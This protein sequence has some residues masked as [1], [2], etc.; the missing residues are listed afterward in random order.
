M[1]ESREI[2]AQVKDQARVREF[3]KELV[4]HQ[5]RILAFILT[6]VPDR[7]DAEDILQETLYEMWN[8]FDTFTPGTNFVA[9]GVTIAKYKVLRFREKH[10]RS[11]LQFS[12]DLLETLQQEG[13]E[14][15]NRMPEYLAALRSCRRKLAER[16]GY[17]VQMRYEQGL[18]YDAMASHLGRSLQAVHKNLAKIH[19]KL[20]RCMRLTLRQEGL[21]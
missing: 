18:T 10:A 5:G 3:L 12:S 17:L 13:T 19:T 6:M 9:W 15:L 20:V 16:E 4:P 8:R 14:V 2:F 7:V 11:R 21:L 1:T